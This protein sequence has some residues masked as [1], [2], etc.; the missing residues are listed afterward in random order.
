MLLTYIVIFWIISN[1][2]QTIK[3]AYVLTILIFKR[4]ARAAE[5]LGDVNLGVLKVQR[6]ANKNRHG[7]PKQY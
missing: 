3:Q 5:P 4:Y 1:C 2:I 6:H 7:A